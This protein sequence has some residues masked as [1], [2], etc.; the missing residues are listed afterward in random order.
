MRVVPRK[1]EPV[2][3]GVSKAFRSIILPHLGKAFKDRFS[4]DRVNAAIGLHYLWI[5]DDQSKPVPAII[6][7]CSRAYHKDAERILKATRC[8]RM[9]EGYK[10]ELCLDDTK[11]QHCAKTANHSELQFPEMEIIPP[12]DIAAFQEAPFSSSPTIRNFKPQVQACVSGRQKSTCLGRATATLLPFS[13]LNLPLPAS[14]STSDRIPNALNRVHHMHMGLTVHHILESDTSPM[15]DTIAKPPQTSDTGLSQEITVFNDSA[16]EIIIVDADLEDLDSDISKRHQ[17][18]DPVS[19][20]ITDREASVSIPSEDK[21]GMLRASHGARDSVNQADA[22]SVPMEI[23]MAGVASKNE[24]G[25]SYILHPSLEPGDRSATSPAS[26]LFPN[27][28][29]ISYSSGYRTD[30]SDFI[31]DWAYI[32]FNNSHE[33]DEGLHLS[34]LTSSSDYFR[35]FEGIEQ[36][37]V[38]DST[39]DAFLEPKEVS[40]ILAGRFY[41]KGRTSSLPSFLSLNTR[42]CNVFGMAFSVETEKKIGEF[43]GDPR[44]ARRFDG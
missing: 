40:I 6:V 15:D 19:H 33:G 9:A 43:N 18:S 3:E 27:L 28:P 44:D 23:L 21:S 14:S 25:L 30:E 7:S 42:R 17:G 8:S 22:L 35:A 41:C 39:S 1:E 10:F 11:V 37:H 20:S 4:R 12:E 26:L 38:W 5:G 36:Y 16:S 29:H 2:D 31:M 13:L 32:S 34:N 24:G